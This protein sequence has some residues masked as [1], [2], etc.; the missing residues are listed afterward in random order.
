LA[1][2][3]RSR[4]LDAVAGDALSTAAAERLIEQ[5]LASEPR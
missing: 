3:E 2:I 1:T 4:F 5:R